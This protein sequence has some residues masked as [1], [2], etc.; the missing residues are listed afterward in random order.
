MKIF[1]AHGYPA[2]SGKADP[3]LPCYN[4]WHSIRL[5]GNFCARCCFIHSQI[6]A[7]CAA[8]LRNCSHCRRGSKDSMLKK[9]K[10][11][12]KRKD[13]VE[14]HNKEADT[15]PAKSKAAKS[16]K[17]AAKPVAAKAKAAAKPAPAKK[18][19]ATPAAKP[20]AEKAKAEAAP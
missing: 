3:I 14:R 4:C 7:V 11:I 12:F 18:T 5:S 15:M 2:E 6:P 20:V 16:Q 13:T 8:S 19:P 9:I 1:D 10:D 17:P